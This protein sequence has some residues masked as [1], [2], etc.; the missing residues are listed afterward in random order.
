MDLEI[1]G[2]WVEVSLGDFEDP[3]SSYAV[4]RTGVCRKQKSALCGMCLNHAVGSKFFRCY[5]PVPCRRRVTGPAGGA[6]G[7]RRWLVLVGGPRDG[8]EISGSEEVE[9]NTWGCQA[10]LR[11]PVVNPKTYRRTSPRALIPNLESPTPKTLNP[12][13]HRTN[14]LKSKRPPNSKCP[15]RPNFK[16]RSRNSQASC[17]AA[18]WLPLGIRVL[19]IS[20]LGLRVLG[21]GVSGL[22]FAG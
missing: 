2:A 8:A 21:F 6:C 15:K 9:V 17:R 1:A 7:A 12:K 11:M 22:G 13:T 16:L 5:L 4:P 19:R 20:G 18:S 3:F 14:S 10:A